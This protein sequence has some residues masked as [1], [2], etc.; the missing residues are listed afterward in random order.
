MLGILSKK[1]FAD[2]TTPRQLKDYCDEYQ[3]ECDKRESDV[4]KRILQLYGY[5]PLSKREEDSKCLINDLTKIFEDYYKKNPNISAVYRILHNNPVNR[6]ALHNYTYNYPEKYHCLD[7]YLKLF[8]T[9]QFGE[10]K[11]TSKKRKTSRTI[12]SRRSKRPRSRKT[13]KK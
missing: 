10:G 1:N 4:N 5:T 13:N 11:K 8:T 12:G 6:V 7:K 2:F 3:K 9:G